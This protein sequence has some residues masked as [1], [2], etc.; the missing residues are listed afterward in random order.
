MGFAPSL[1]EAGR[2]VGS[3]WEAMRSSQHGSHDVR[4]RPSEA[5]EARG[6][7]P[8]ACIVCAGR[9]ARRL[10]FCGGLADGDV[11]HQ[12]DEARRA[13][14]HLECRMLSGHS[15]PLARAD[16]GKVGC[17]LT[18]ILRLGS[19]R[20][21]VLRRRLC[22]HVVCELVSSMRH[23]V[24]VG[25]HLRIIVRTHFLDGEAFSCECDG[26]SFPKRSEAWRCWRT[27]P[28]C[29]AWSGLWLCRDVHRD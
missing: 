6:S 15:L 13:H 10:N 18:R 28:A 4:G 17:V 7:P 23:A 25:R 8:H 11:S 14:P 2:A 5:S 12:D 20:S 29:R 16:W 21:W 24:W 1:F 19:M 3:R 27:R 9:V 26:P 22:A